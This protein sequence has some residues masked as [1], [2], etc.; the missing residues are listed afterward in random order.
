[1]I[2]NTGVPFLDTATTFMVREFTIRDLQITIPIRPEHSIRARDVI[3]WPRRGWRPRLLSLKS[4][5]GIWARSG[6]VCTLEKLPSC[7]MF[8]DD[9]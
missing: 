8:K 2:D 5:R 9:V 1:M 6:P 3:R 4:N 7:P